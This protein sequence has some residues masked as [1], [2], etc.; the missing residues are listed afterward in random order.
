MQLQHTHCTVE[1]CGRPHKARGYCQTHYMQFKRGAPVVAEIKSRVHGR[2]PICTVDGCSKAERANGLCDMHY[3][4]VKR[5]GSTEFRDRSRSLKPC[6]FPGCDRPLLSNGYCQR[7]ALRLRKLT[8][9][10]LTMEWFI[11]TGTRQNWLCLICDQPETSVFVN[12]GEIRELAIDHCHEHGHAR[13]L[14]CNNCNRAIG[15]LRDDPV[16]LR[17]AADYL[18]SHKPLW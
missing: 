1:G 10:G 16:V 7:H 9:F 15:L 13:G 5:H 4:R 8:E 14:L 6:G 2:D 3:M 17:K 12:S 11:E 18:D